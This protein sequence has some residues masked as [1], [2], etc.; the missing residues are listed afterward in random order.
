MHDAVPTLT[1]TPCLWIGSQ[2]ANGRFYIEQVLGH[3]GMGIVYRAFDS[4][5]RERVALKTMQNCDA[6]SVY[7]LKNEFRALAD[8]DHPN[9]VRLF[10]L[11]NEGGHC[12]FTMELVRGE[13][14]DHWVRPNGQLDEARL[15][16][17]L[18]QL[19]DAIAAL[20]A[21]GKLHRDIKPSNTLVTE[22]G[23]VVVLDFGLVSEQG[24]G[25][26]GQ[27]STSR[28]MIAGTPDYLAP[29]QALGSAPTPA[30]DAYA[31]GVMLFETLNGQLPFRGTGAEVLIAKQQGE[32]GW[33]DGRR[34]LPK[35]LVTL[36]DQLLRRDPRERLDLVAMRS[37]S[38]RGSSSRTDSLHLQTTQLNSTTLIG[39]DS[40][41]A[42]LRN[43][44]EK[45]V[46]GEG[47]VV[48][49]SGE[50]GIGK[51]SLCD[52]FIDELTRD[53]QALV[54]R[55][56]CNERENVS[57]KALDALVDNLS[58]VLRR[59]S[60]AEGA[61]LLPRDVGALVKLF[62]VLARVDT[63]AE[64]PGRAT[65]DPHAERHRAFEAL[66]ELLGRMRDRR[67]LVI[68]IDDLQWIDRDSSLLLAHLVSHTDPS[69]SLI[70]LSH[71]TE[72]LEPNELLE[73]VLDA[74]VA[75]RTLSLQRLTLKPLSQDSS[76]KLAN[77]VFFEP[78]PRASMV[79]DRIG[80]E[81]RGNP[82][83]INELARFAASV[84]AHEARDLSLDLALTTRLNGFTAAARRV[85]AVLAVAGHPLPPSLAIDAADASHAD[86]DALDAAHFI[87]RFSRGDSKLLELYH[88][89]LSATFRQVLSEQ[90]RHDTYAALAR[91]SNS[92]S[93]ID[94]EVRCAFLEGSGD[95][96]G[97]AACAEEAANRAATSFA[98]DHSA[99]LYS[100]ALDLGIHDAAA[101]LYLTSALAQ[102]LADAGRCEES[103]AAYEQAALLA[104]GHQQI[105]FQRRRAYQLLSAGHMTEGAE[106]VSELCAKVGLRTGTG[107]LEVSSLAV[108]L[109]ELLNAEIDYSAK[110]CT[111]DPESVLR[112]EL[113]HI[114]DSGLGF[115]Y[116]DERAQSVAA[117]YLHEAQ[118]QRDR[119]HLA[120]AI[121][122]IIVRLAPHVQC[123]E[124]L[125]TL[126]ELVERNGEPELSAVLHWAHGVIARRNG[127]NR[128]ARSYFARA[129]AAGS[130]AGT[131][132]AQS[133]VD[134]IH[135]YD[136]G[137]ANS[138]GDYAD[139]S[140][141]TP[142]WVEDAFRR[143]RVWTAA[144]LSGAWGM[145]AW[146]VH[147]DVAG[148]RLTLN[149]A[150]SLWRQHAAH[151]SDDTTSLGLHRAEAM[152]S[153]YERNPL[154]GLRS[155]EQTQEWNVCPGK[156]NGLQYALCA[157]SVLG[158]AWITYFSAPDQRGLVAII[159]DTASLLQSSS[160]P[161]FAHMLNAACAMHCNDF[162]VA[163]RELEHAVKRFEALSMSMLAAG[164]RRRL[165][166][167]LGGDEGKVL[168]RA[169]D[170]FM[171]EQNVANP[172]A[173]TE[174]L[175]PGC[176]L[177]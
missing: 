174:M 29:E 129:L 65:T 3:G 28:E 138:C 88:D 30:S 66:N 170:R 64:A 97:A 7:A 75:S 150:R 110:Q 56:R 115:H 34:N 165:G 105:D 50:S 100:K 160:G 42:H 52:V 133:F 132:W 94:V 19:V 158:S 80:H 114:L 9:L 23:H 55:G 164:A 82:F 53:G 81:A 70:V 172:D 102:V 142:A 107:R 95:L 32:P 116:F 168:I 72:L 61:A 11:F 108:E 58:R 60:T 143:G 73:A 84:G 20:H 104:H 112:L 85:T 27:S 68:V 54:L 67:P 130:R 31:L 57:F 10:E 83:L 144:A 137:C 71:R 77:R 22:D 14:F 122:T 25:A 159:R 18:S 8:F 177:R 134:L 4:V 173:L 1:I 140:H 74:A 163:A 51:S 6:A 48:S 93:D 161:P 91:A 40:E 117:M 78:L 44:Y 79:I 109:T 111:S 37:L 21:Y 98:F 176:E 147:D 152:L 62:P 5:R 154:A 151:L 24:P 139:L 169:S 175:C 121:T 118:H 89:Q 146:L 59:L 16:A 149:R 167:L 145:P 41:L 157:A 12:F 33:P 135:V 86:L 153:L 26:I 99:H 96:L 136:Q 171:R 2:V 124:L 119:R 106:L 13:H 141:C 103:A 101:R 63:F 123:T 166:E 46:A 39:R 131:D 156:G 45:S 125:S 113:L 69:P 38:A 155:L 127:Q 35:D 126:K 120:F 49:L 87:R 17:A 148:Y 92:R 128:E 47:V 76:Q 162:D 15:R 36:C 43:A 90:A